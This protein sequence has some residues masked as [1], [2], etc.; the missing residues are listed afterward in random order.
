MDMMTQLKSQRF[1]YRIVIYNRK[2]FLKLILVVIIKNI[3]NKNNLTH[4]T[5]KIYY[6]IV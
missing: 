6:S 5:V 4:N 3:I 1:I 2:Q